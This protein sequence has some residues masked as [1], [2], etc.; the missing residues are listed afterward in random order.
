MNYVKIER[1]KSNNKTKTQQE[2]EYRKINEQLERKW[3]GEI[4][5]MSEE[6]KTLQQ[7]LKKRD[8]QL[9]ELAKTCMSLS[10]RF[11]EANSVIKKLEKTQHLFMDWARQQ[12]WELPEHIRTLLPKNKSFMRKAAFDK[13]PYGESPAEYCFNILYFLSLS[14]KD[15]E[16]LGATVFQRKKA[17]RPEDFATLK[18]VTKELHAFLF[19]FTDDKVKMEAK[20]GYLQSCVPKYSTDS[21]SE[22][23]RL[24]KLAVNLFPVYTRVTVKRGVSRGS[25]YS[26]YNMARKASRLAYQLIAERIS[27]EDRWG[28]KQEKKYYY[29]IQTKYDS[30]KGT[31]ELLQP[32]HNWEIVNYGMVNYYG[33][34]NV[35]NLVMDNNPPYKEG[36]QGIVQI[37]WAGT[38]IY[39]SA[40]D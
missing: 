17:E 7:Q 21:N 34:F 29:R 36:S 23:M 25:T 35:T 30:E 24:K 10:K 28:R 3:K 33:H 4:K 22:W 13:V 18:N 32:T 9:G 15:Q 26:N 5:T 20:Y 27:K 14:E 39:D 37:L 8:I 19:H 11:E 16:E 38:C 6:K 40:E 1:V 2:R 12:E 31:F